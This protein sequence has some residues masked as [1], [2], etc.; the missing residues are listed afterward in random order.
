MILE[1]VRCEILC[2]IYSALESNCSLD[3][4]AALFRVHYIQN[5]I[6]RVLE[7]WNISMVQYGGDS[8]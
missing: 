6:D 4:R 2:G 5:G 3:A 7:L 8:D 1:D